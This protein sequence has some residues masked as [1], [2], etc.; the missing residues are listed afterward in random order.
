MSYLSILIFKILLIKIITQEKNT[1][2]LV[3]R[4]K[5]FYPLNS[6]ISQNNTD[7]N[8]ND[9]VNSYLS[10]QI[11]LE[12]ETGNETDY[13]KGT[14]QILNTF[15]NSKT[16]SFILRNKIKNNSVLCNYNS[17]LSTTFKSKELSSS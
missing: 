12:F 11:Y 16:T 1:D 17:S 14:N 13:Q 2:I 5:T 10:S 15:I 6:N 3:L 8:I 9:F 4:F 7:Y